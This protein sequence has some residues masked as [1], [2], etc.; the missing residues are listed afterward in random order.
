MP[1]G[2]T[3]QTYRALWA[4]VVLQAKADLDY[5]PIGSILF[6]QAVAFFV[7]RGE[8]AE[9]RRMVADCL[10][11]H[12]D[13]LSSRGARWIADRRQREGFAPEPGPVLRSATPAPWPRLVAVPAADTYRRKNHPATI[14][15]VNPF[16]PL[17][18]MAA[19]A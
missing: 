11:M 19:S 18:H 17:R 8:W 12:P 14:S 15:A 5:E 7:S 16:N 13:D 6:D 2:E 10:D 9:S 3:Q 1:A 4:Q